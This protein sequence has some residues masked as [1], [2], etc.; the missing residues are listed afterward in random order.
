M[1]TAPCPECQEP[2]RAAEI[3]LERRVGGRVFSTRVQGL[4]CRACGHREADAAIEERFTLRVA[5]EL[6]NDASGESLKFMR[7]ALHLRASELAELLGVSPETMSRWENDRRPV[8][9]ASFTVVAAMVRDALEGRT[10]M[11]DTLR[12]LATG[13]SS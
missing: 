9:R 1:R 7:A 10:A 8:P 12:A 4:H 11:R 13:K 6:S 3:D 5:E 2:L